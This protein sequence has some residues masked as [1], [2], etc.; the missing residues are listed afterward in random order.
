[1]SRLTLAIGVVLC[2]SCAAL[3][4]QT[5]ATVDDVDAPA[6]S[7]REVTADSE[8]NI[9]VAGS[10]KD[11]TTRNHAV[12]MRSTDG[13]AIWETSADFPATIDEVVG[14]PG[15]AASFSAIASAHVASGENHIVAAG[16]IRQVF[17]AAGPRTG[18]W[19]IIR[20]KDAGATWE[21]VDEYSPR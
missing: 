11:E 14:P 2:A 10:M 7:A 17:S 1:M 15:P 21:T 9:F 3:H 5:W 18:Q 12:I 4:A 6:A 13:G 19:L 20:S 16:R 8:G